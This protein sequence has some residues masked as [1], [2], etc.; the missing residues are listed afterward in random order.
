MKD[1]LNEGL[2]TDRFMVEWNIRQEAKEETPLP[3]K[4]I[5]IVTTGMNDQGFPY[6]KDYHSETNAE[7]ARHLLRGGVF[8]CYRGP[9]L[10]I[11]AFFLLF[12]IH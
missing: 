11:T 10:M 9:L 5:H 8:F 12:F 7:V 1:T 6:I 2:S 3:D 4:A